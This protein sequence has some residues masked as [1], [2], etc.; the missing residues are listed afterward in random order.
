ML[1]C[2]LRLLQLKTKGFGSKD[3]T[4]CSFWL[5]TSFLEG[6]MTVL[7]KP[8]M[9]KCHQDMK[10]HAKFD[11]NFQITLRHTDK[12]SA[13][14]ETA[15]TGGPRRSFK[16]PGAPS[17]VMPTFDVEETGSPSGR[18][19]AAVNNPLAPERPAAGLK[20]GGDSSGGASVVEI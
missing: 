11:R 6:G 16:L 5:N 2:C 7:T 13:D 17:K 3:K 10:K 4:M 19:A 15:A 12:L 14:F 20:P 1:F 18:A 9:D 8:E